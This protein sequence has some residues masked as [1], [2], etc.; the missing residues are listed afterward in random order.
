MKNLNELIEATGELRRLAPG[1]QR[2]AAI[3]QLRAEGLAAIREYSSDP[4]ARKVA[5][6][7]TTGIDDALNGTPPDSCPDCG[8][9]SW[10][11]PGQVAIGMSCDH[12]WHEAARP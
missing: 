10:D 6:A 1:R 4:F 2:T 7:M 8:S 9:Q 11:L 12:R 3:D 5:E